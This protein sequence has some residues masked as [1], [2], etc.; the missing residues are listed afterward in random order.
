MKRQLVTHGR[1]NKEF[2]SNMKKLYPHRTMTDATRELNKV[3]EDILYG[4][5]R[6]RI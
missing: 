2:A 1:I 5:K 6:K 4:K 3:L